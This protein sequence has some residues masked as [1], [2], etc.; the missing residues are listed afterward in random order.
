MYTSTMRRSLLATNSQHAGNFGQSILPRNWTALAYPSA[1][2][3]RCQLKDFLPPCNSGLKH[4]CVRR[5]F[6]IVSLSHVYML[7]F[8]FSSII[9]DVH[10]KATKSK[11]KTIQEYLKEA[12]EK[13]FRCLKRT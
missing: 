11:S 9:Y 12:M 7:P 3:I 6:K 13:E 8:T 5:K 2:L 4:S 10:L 1:W